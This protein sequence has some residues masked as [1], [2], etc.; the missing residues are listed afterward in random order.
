[1]YFPLVI[2]FFAALKN[3]EIYEQ[4]G[5]LHS[6]RLKGDIL[7]GQLILMLNIFILLDGNQK[8]LVLNCIF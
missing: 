2:R 4:I 7:I 5:H 6:L 1:M 8:S 3:L